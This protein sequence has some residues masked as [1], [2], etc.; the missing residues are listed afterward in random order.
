MKQKILF[1]GGSLNQTT[2]MHSIARHLEGEY[3]CY[4]SPMYADGLLRRLAQAGYLDFTIMGGRFRQQTEAYLNEHNLKVDYRGEAHDY[5]LVL[6][7]TDLIVPRN[8]RGR[9]FILVQEGMT[10]PENLA[11]YLVKWLGLPRYLASTSTN[12]LSNAYDLFCVASAGYRDLFIRKGV[13]AEKIAVTGIPNYDNAARLLHNDFPFHDY[14]LVATSDARET[15][16]WDNRK[17]F[18]RHCLDVAR[19]RQLLFKLHPNEK[20]ERAMREIRA[21][22]SDALIFTDSPIDPMIANCATLITQYSTVVYTGI[23]LG[24]EVHS[25]FDVNMLKRLAPIQNGGTSGMHIAAACR[26]LLTSKQWLV[27]SE[28][29]PFA[30]TA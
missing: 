16:K 11:Y 1:I 17:K 3:D 26:T 13:P 21:Q 15:G 7:G 12:G 9:K 30:I 23:A 29:S 20:R 24:K 4:F 22:A 28:L 10:D 27:N 25:Y 18:I 6:M 8:V 19:G 5:A 14:V 2:Q